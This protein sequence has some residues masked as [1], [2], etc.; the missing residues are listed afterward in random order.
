MS[1]VPRQ[2]L[3]IYLEAGSPNEYLLVNPSLL[4]EGILLLKRFFQNGLPPFHESPKG[5]IHLG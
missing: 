3:D 1:L 5:F 2:H 4:K